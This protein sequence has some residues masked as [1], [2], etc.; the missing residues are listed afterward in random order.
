MTNIVVKVASVMICFTSC[1]NL[2]RSSSRGR[3]LGHLK[4]SRSCG[5]KHYELI[6]SICYLYK[7][8][9]SLEALKQA[10]QHVAK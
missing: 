3:G 6:L 8:I 7:G 2:T 5:P 1:S 10:H 4:S 9:S